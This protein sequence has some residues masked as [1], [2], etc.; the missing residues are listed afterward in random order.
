MLFGAT[1]FT[2]RLAA[3]YIARQYGSKQFRWAIAGRRKEGLEKIREELANI[4]PTLT[5][6][7]LVL[8]QLCIVVTS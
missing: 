4:D 2:G 8:F 3:L 7:S 5:D 6:L 1:G